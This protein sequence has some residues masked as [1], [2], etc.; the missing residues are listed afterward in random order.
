MAGIETWNNDGTFSLNPDLAGDM[1]TDDA[2]KTRQAR[3]DAWNA[4]ARW[5]LVSMDVEGKRTPLKEY[6]TQ[7]GKAVTTPG[8]TD[9]ASPSVTTGGV[10]SLRANPPQVSGPTVLESSVEVESLLGEKLKGKGYALP[11]LEKFVLVAVPPHGS[12]EK[13]TKMAWSVWLGGNLIHANTPTVK[14][15]EHLDTANVALEQAAKILRRS[16]LAEVEKS[17]SSQSPTSQKDKGEEKK[18]ESKAKIEDFGE[19]IS[20]AKKEYAAAYKDK[21]KTAQAVDIAAE[22]LSKSWPEPDYDKLLEAGHDSYA[23]ALVRS[24]RDEI[25]NKPGKSRHQSWKISTWVDQV[26]S[27]RDTADRLLNEPEYLAAWRKKVAEK[28]H[29]RL[30]DAIGGRAELYQ[31]LGHGKTLKGIRIRRGEYSVYGGVS[32]KPAKVV[33]TVERDAKATAF[34]NMPQELGSGDTR[35]EAL[36]S[37]AA[38]YALLDT[39]KEKQS[40]TK[41]EIYST[42]QGGDKPYFIGKKVGR[43]V[44]R[45]KEGFAKAMDA[46]L[47]LA[48]HNEELTE[49]LEQKKAIPRERY[50]INQPRV[51]A[52]MRNAQDVTPEMFSEAFGFRGVQ[53]GNYVEGGRRQKD[54]NNAFD[55]LMDMAAVLNI[56]PKALSFNG[57]LGLAFGARG[58]GGK[59]APAA[60]YEPTQIVINLTKREGAGS[61]AHEWWHGLSNYFSRL[62]GEKSK[63]IADALDVSLAARGSDFFH[64]GHIRREMVQAFGAVVKAINSTAMRER[65][66]SL[67]S[68]RTKEY[69]GTGPEMSARAFERYVIAKLHDQGASNDYLA[70]V[71]SEEYWEAADALGIGEGGSYPYPTVSELPAI[72]GGFDE[73]FATIQTKE[74]DKGTALYSET[75][76]Q[77]T[78]KPP[79]KLYRGAAEGTTGTGAYSMGKGLYSTPDKSF[80]AKYG[81]V[82]EVSVEDY[83]PSRPLVI[84][85]AAGGA[86]QALTDWLLKE[87][88]ERNIREFNKKY[89]DPGEFIASRG[90][91]GVIAGDEVVRYPGVKLSKS[92]TQPT[93]NTVFKVK[94]E[95][96]KILSPAA[97]L[98]KKRLEVVQSLGQLPEHI[99]KFL[100]MVAWHGSAS[101][102]DK[103]ST[104]K[105][106]TGEGAQAYG[107]G[108]YFASARN[109]AEWYQSNLTATDITVDGQKYYLA[110]IRDSVRQL[111]HGENGDVD[112]AIAVAKGNVDYWTNK[113]KSA[114]NATES[115]KDLDE[116]N[117][118]K[119]REAVKKNKGAL[120]QV[121][122]APADDEFLLWDRPLSEQSEK[123]KKALEKLPANVLHDIEVNGEDGS[124]IYRGIVKGIG[125]NGNPQILA[126]LQ[127]M[128]TAGEISM[129]GGAEQKA[130]EYLHSLG[131][132]GIKYLDGTSRGAGEGSFNFVIFSDSD[133]EIQAIYSKDGSIAGAFSPADGKI[134]LVSDTIKPGEAPGIYRHEVTHRAMR[135]DRVFSS[136]Y[137][138]LLG[139]FAAL[140]ES[141]PRVAKAFSRVPGDTPAHL[142]NEEGLA[143]FVEQE[144]NRP[145]SMGGK[146][147]MVIRKII[148][149]IRAWLNTHG[150][151]MKLTTADILAMVEQGIKRDIRRSEAT[152]DIRYSKEDSPLFSKQNNKGFGDISDKQAEA[153]KRVGGIATPKTI[154]EWWA[155]TK[156][157]AGLKLTAGIADQFAAIKEVLGEREYKLARMSKGTEGPLEA[158]M[159]FGDLYLDP[160]GVENV[161][162]SGGIVKALQKLNGEQ[163]R[164]FWW[165]A[166]NRAEKLT[167]EERENLFSSQD[168]AELKQ[169][170]DGK[171]PDGS[172]RSKVY[173]EVLKDYNRA[174]K[175]VLDIA[176]QSG[177]I[178][179]DTRGAWESDMYV[180]FYRAKED[181]ISGSRGSQGGLTRQY[182]FKQLKGGTRKLHEDLF[183]NVLM[184]WMHLLDASAKNRAA[185]AALNKAKE[186]G[187]A[188]F[189][190][191]TPKGK[192]NTFYLGRYTKVL[193][194]GTK[195]TEGGV[196]KVSDGT[197]PVEFH[198]KKYFRVDDPLVYEALEA[199]EFTGFN[200]LFFKVAG[201][202]KNMLTMGITANPSFKVRNL[203]RD[204]VAAL[205]QNPMSLNPAKAIGNLA[206]GVNIMRKKDKTYASLLAGRGLIRF[207][208]ILDGTSSRHMDKLINAGVKAG[209]IVDTKEKMADMLTA[210]ADWYN[211]LG[212]ISEGANRASLYNQMIG[213]GK[214][215]AEAA[216]ASRDM[217]DFN[218]HGTAKAVRFLS[219][220][221]PFFNARVQGLYKMGRAGKADPARMGAVIGA[222][223]LASVLLMLAYKDDEEWKKR[224]DWDRD[225]YWWFRIG[226]TAWRIPKPFEVGVMATLAER[227]AEVMASDEMTGK[228]FAERLWAAVTQTLAMN[229]VPQMFKPLVDLY[230]D[231]D[232]FTG[233][234]IEGPALE[235]REV[236]ERYRSRTSETAKLASRAG[237]AVTETVGADFLSPVQVDHLVRGYFGWLGT[238]AVTATDY[239]GRFLQDAPVKP[240]MTLRETFLA[241]SFVET[242]PS[243]SSRYLTEFYDQ[244]K[245]VQQAYSS[246]TA[247]A[248]EG[249][250]AAARDINKREGGS[251]K[252]YNSA[253]TKIQ[254]EISDISS[255][256]RE[257]ERE[258][259]ERWTAERKRSEIDKLNERRN[260]L[261]KRAAGDLQRRQK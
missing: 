7:S 17:L 236:T 261:A 189:M 128:A 87:S 54:L 191:E 204:S 107:H 133:V 100:K 65:A 150:F 188:E 82:S 142:R 95:L 105:I 154:Q 229:P 32:Y 241:G 11:G 101:R 203:I 9:K 51:G 155:E 16:D 130:S 31:L 153:L 164:F 213:E 226:N 73:F 235:R 108:L 40:G 116:L 166:A 187:I 50:D 242:L 139:E 219:Q 123:V 252:A 254:G 231:K 70:N 115:Q 215:H 207:G 55:A 26:K 23:V 98:N 169:L 63:D 201:K 228:R 222:A 42:R 29:L 159:M 234:D 167:A 168:I 196:E 25:P 143:Y 93:G 233:R 244:A 131:I 255:R 27:L 45:I 146:V 120:Y 179:G 59:D 259:G 46:R 64:K 232:S 137:D 214:S 184:N 174:S 223:A 161:D 251:L 220:V 237:Q 216:F 110:N 182:G 8:A 158:M 20:G 193:P 56:P 36:D 221:V 61:L 138:S 256:I 121:E 199:I 209:T 91:D 211:E 12:K 227:G 185:R 35:Q 2:L 152:A 57:E 253:T 200:S 136:R 202:F 186:V 114:R 97:L 15:T 78:V 132:R 194:K 37:F 75:S 58:S 104:E 218:L 60:H 176:E 239:L 6:M 246:M 195:Y 80:A 240:K 52:D 260:R 113:D 79:K 243:G 111:L 245:E 181:G 44:I 106:G 14:A 19:V 103:F 148:A 140:R 192:N 134:W 250:L 92:N 28:E 238:S 69:W 125:Q 43:N 96:S 135:E 183:A 257:I 47:Y 118:L 76:P 3:V 38:K 66:T 83:W 13:A 145:E 49:I 144:T 53:F 4:G 109:I 147:G 205:A 84:R 172:F 247:K 21:M 126:A 170:A 160:S 156:D 151:Q 175:N 99:G 62:R 230:A 178:N 33:W 68:R 102:H 197:T 127:E 206:G 90:Y 141:D 258:K 71:V 89:P 212:D 129:W 210:M 117:D 217:L 34:S 81:Q 119:S 198:G 88:G 225:N 39:G 22:P 86:P 48:E 177:V 122:L 248:K 18:P 162:A 72:R 85:N 157:R 149:H 41:F 249:D 180:P 5:A 224:E 77:P 173:R 74:T 112:Q 190:G 94:R 163:H 165:I 171:M 124:A 1:V 67:D 24:M 208:T 30:D 10:T